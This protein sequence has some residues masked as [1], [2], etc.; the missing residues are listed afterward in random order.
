M[1]SYGMLI[2]LLLLS[3]PAVLGAQL[4]SD[5]S[6]SS[7]SRHQAGSPIVSKVQ[8]SQHTGQTSQDAA[9]EPFDFWVLALVW[10][11]AIVAAPAQSRTRHAV[12]R[13]EAHAGFWTH[14]LW[15]PCSCQAVLLHPVS[16]WCIS[17]MAAAACS[18]ADRV[19]CNLRAALLHTIPDVM[20]GR[21]KVDAF[22]THG[23]LTDFYTPCRWPVKVQEGAKATV[24]E[25][26][27]K[28]HLDPHSL[29]GF[30]AALRFYLR[31][32]NTVADATGE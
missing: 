30:E 23:N 6:E 17:T 13:K 27:S 10:P 2:S 7:S 32:G 21:E 29:V 3:A 4:H 31:S 16:I 26:C 28:R 14:G 19:R 11:P 15:V 12:I 18:Y 20:S 8:D 9:P 25:H 24:L 22:D 5:R 1:W